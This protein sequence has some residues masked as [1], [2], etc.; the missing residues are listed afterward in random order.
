MITVLV[1]THG[2]LAGELVRTA[3]L[4]VGKQDN[5]VA[6]NLAQQDSLA[7]LGSRIGEILGD[8][9]AADGFLILTDMLGGTPCN[10]C[11]PYSSSAH[12]LEIVTGVNL[13]MMLSAFMHRAVMPLN[14]LAQKVI[15]DGQKSI[16]DAKAMFL[17]KIGKQ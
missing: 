1:I 12:P 10:A 4:I 7:T 6:L 13:Y 11:L 16:A 9:A 5:V 2:Q 15:T 3:E 17:S 8:P 14:E